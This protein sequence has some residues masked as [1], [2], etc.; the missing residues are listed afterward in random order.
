MINEEKK[1]ALEAAYEPYLTKE[2]VPSSGYRS[3]R[4]TVIQI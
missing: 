3:I 1:K 2:I 4:L